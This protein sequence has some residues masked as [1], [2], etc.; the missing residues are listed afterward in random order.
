MKSFKSEEIGRTF[1]LRL[2]QGDMV[3]ESIKNL[4]SKEKIKDAFVISGIG[5]LDKCVLHM[6]TTIGYPP[7]E[8]FKKW[9]DEPLELVSIDGIVADSE[10]H[11]HA[12]V[13]DTKQAYAGHLEDGCRILYLGEIVLMEIKSLNLKRIYNDK[14]ILQL[15]KK[16]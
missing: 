11:L 8:Y 3:L 5:T 2:D 9:E 1:I 7:K 6:V 4:I 16:G 15:T 12:V 13:S 14:N 10:P